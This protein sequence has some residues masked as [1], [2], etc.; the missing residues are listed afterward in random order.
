MPATA[1]TTPAGTG[2]SSILAENDEH[3]DRADEQRDTQQGDPS[4]DPLRF[5]H[6]HQLRTLPNMTTPSEPNRI[7]GAHAATAGRHQP[8]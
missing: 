5:V 8:L 1:P 2:H 6:T 7:V 4:G 3:G